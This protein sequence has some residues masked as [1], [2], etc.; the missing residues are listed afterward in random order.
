MQAGRI[1][2]SPIGLV[3]DPG[4]APTCFKPSRLPPE[5]QRLLHL[6]VRCAAA[7]NCRSRKEK[8]LRIAP[9]G[10][11]PMKLGATHPVL[12]RLGPLGSRAVLGLV[13]RTRC[14]DSELQQAIGSP[15]S[16]QGTAS[17]SSAR[18]HLKAAPMPIDGLN[19]TA[20]NGEG[21]SSRS[22]LVMV[23]SNS[24]FR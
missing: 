14:I 16:L 7:R 11:S 18:S 9:E 17:S 4:L 12:K 2:G 15:R 8:A 20:R 21:P 3:N 6:E 13:A 1:L 10:S 24:S 19:S 5:N 22:C 23:S